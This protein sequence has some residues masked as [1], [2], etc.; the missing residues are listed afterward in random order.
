MVAPIPTCTGAGNSRI[1]SNTENADATISS[2]E[3]AASRN[4]FTREIF[5]ETLSMFF[6]TLSPIVIAETVHEL[7]C[8][9]V[10]RK[11]KNLRRCDNFRKKINTNHG[12]VEVDCSWKND[13][14]RLHEKQQLN[15]PT[16]AK[17]SNC[18]DW[19]QSWQGEGKFAR[20]WVLKVIFPNTLFPSLPLFCGGCFKSFIWRHASRLSS[21]QCCP[22]D[23]IFYSSSKSYMHHIFCDYWQKVCKKKF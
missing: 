2:S 10:S 11:R 18:P 15:G 14:L 3:L 23:T 19:F 6:D 22:R 8:D 16:T 4:G 5:L 13:G 12:N 20:M 1:L 17:P 9:T 21:V 7:C